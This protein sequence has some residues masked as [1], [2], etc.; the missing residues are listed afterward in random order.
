LI[1]HSF[2]GITV[3]GASADCKEA[4]AVISI[5]P[6]FYPK[7]EETPLGASDHQKVCVVLSELFPIA[8]SNSEKGPVDTFSEIQKYSKLSKNK[9]E[10]TI[11]KTLGHFN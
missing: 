5:D 9:A 7:K 2:G 11:L 6:W 8:V 1:G 4:Q 10:V 3:L